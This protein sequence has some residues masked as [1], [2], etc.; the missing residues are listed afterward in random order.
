MNMRHQR[1]ELER[2]DAIECEAVRAEQDFGFLRSA[3][4]QMARDEPG[5]DVALSMLGAD[6]DRAHAALQLFA[7]QR[8]LPLPTLPSEPASPAL[9]KPSWRVAEV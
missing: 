3:W 1:A 2:I 8:Q 7:G 9:A 4:L 5:N 6:M